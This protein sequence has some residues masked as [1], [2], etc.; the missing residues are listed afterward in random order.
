MSK[1]L[2][3]FCSH[4][5][6]YN[7][8]YLLTKDMILRMYFENITWVIWFYQFKLNILSTGYNKSKHLDILK[9]TTIFKLTDTMDTH[10]WIPCHLDT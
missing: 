3:D 4:L 5:D 8:G 2:A 1:H 6:L 9:K 10:M 7:F